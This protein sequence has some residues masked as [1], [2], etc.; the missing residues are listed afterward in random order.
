MVEIRIAVRN[1]RPG[2]ASMIGRAIATA[3]VRIQTPGPTPTTANSP[4][5][6]VMASMRCHRR[7]STGIAR[8]P[9]DSPTRAAT[10]S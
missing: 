6:N 10:T 5:R 1:R 8:M 4:A 7:Y 2:P 9:D 3:G